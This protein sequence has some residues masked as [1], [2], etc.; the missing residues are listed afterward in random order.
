MMS[1]WSCRPTI[2]DDEHSY[3]CAALHLDICRSD[4]ASYLFAAWLSQSPNVLQYILRKKVRP[5][6]N[7]SSPHSDIVH[8]I[9][10]QLFHLIQSDRRPRGLC[11]TLRLVHRCSFNTGVRQIRHFISRPIS[12][13][14]KPLQIYQP[15]L[16]TNQSKEC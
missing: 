2:N 11:L 6:R 14:R 10:S 8:G 3:V 16:W 15:E 1:P 4:P 7:T 13:S 12:G 5:I 9:R